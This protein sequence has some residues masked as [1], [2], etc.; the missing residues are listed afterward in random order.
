MVICPPWETRMESVA[1]T[2]TFPVSPAAPLDERAAISLG[3]VAFAPSTSTRAAAISTVPARP[4]VEKV[5]ELTLPPFESRSLSSTFTEML[6]ASPELADTEDVE[7]PVR[8]PVPAP[9]MSRLPA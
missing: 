8:L 6:P 7:R 5:D 1:A 9:S 4:A 2:E 3:L